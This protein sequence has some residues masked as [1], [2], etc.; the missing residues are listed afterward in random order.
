VL[1]TFVVANADVPGSGLLHVD[2]HGTALVAGNAYWLLAGA[3]GDGLFFWG[4][5]SL[6]PR[7]TG[8][9][10]DI[11]PFPVCIPEQVA[12]SEGNRAALRVE[13]NVPEPVSLALVGMGLAGLGW[14]RR[15]RS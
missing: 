13:A 12:F 7:D 10:V 2:A 4:E 1:D 3:T 5:N 8:I 11:C 15:R 14:S 6:T 9:H